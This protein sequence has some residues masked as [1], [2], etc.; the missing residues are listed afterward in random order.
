MFFSLLSLLSACSFSEHRATTNQTHMLLE[1]AEKHRQHALEAKEQ[2]TAFKEIGSALQLYL[3]VEQRLK[4][5]GATPS[6]ELYIAIANSYALL[7]TGGSSLFYYRQALV[8]AP[9]DKALQ[10]QINRL[11]QSLKLPPTSFGSFPLSLQEMLYLTI[12]LLTLSFVIASCSIWLHSKRLKQ[13][14]LG[15]LLLACLPLLLALYI[16]AALPLEATVI[17]S[18]PIY[19]LPQSPSSS[20]A[21]HT[22]LGLEGTQVEVLG[23]TSDPTWLMIRLRKTSEKDSSEAGTPFYVPSHS[24]RLIERKI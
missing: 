8:N 5:T 18:T 11:E 15:V 4:K 1:E 14:S 10:A 19:R 12:A 22:H 23:Q 17:E 24:I 13:L 3:Q 6:N 2:E 20:A 7:R 21:P 9:R 16:A